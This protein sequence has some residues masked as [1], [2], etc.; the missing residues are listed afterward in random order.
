MYDKSCTSMIII[1]YLITDY[2]VEINHKVAK[3]KGWFEQKR[4]SIKRC[5]CSIC[6]MYVG[7]MYHS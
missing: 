6:N 4:N 3:I 7:I 1:M 5:I 2:R